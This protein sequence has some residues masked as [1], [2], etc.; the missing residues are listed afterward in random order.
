MLLEEIKNIKSGKKDLRNFGLTFGV[1]LG[2][3]GMALWWKGRD[4]YAIS[5]GLS[6]AFFFFA[7]MLPGVLKPLQKA[8]M[9]VAVVIGFFMTKVI[10][11]IL[12]FLVFTS[13]GLGMRLFGKK[14]LDMKIDKSRESYWRYRES[15]TFNKST[16]EKQ[17]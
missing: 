8:W 14:L 1:V 6:I 3:L 4:T 9:T 11:S 16:Y 13:I 10:L 5:I 17:F 15:K 7:F 12:F 2:L